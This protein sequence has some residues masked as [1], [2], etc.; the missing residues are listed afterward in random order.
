MHLA[1]AIG[2]FLC[3]WSV[4]YLIDIYFRARSFKRYIQFVESTGLVISPFQVRWYTSLFS[5]LLLSSSLLRRRWMR[6]FCGGWF[7]VGVAAA[8]AAS[9]FTTAFLTM[10]IW[11]QLGIGQLLFSRHRS[12]MT[13][14]Y[15]NDDDDLA[16]AAYSSSSRYND[17]GVVSTSTLTGHSIATN[18]DIGLIPIVP[19]VNVPWSQVPMFLAALAMAGIFHEM[20]RCLLSLSICHN[21]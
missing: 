6:V 17:G 14:N 3:F 12:Q 11:R 19:G 5:P 7:S 20:G 16:A 21:I 15:S 1:T 4:L 10:I 2:L 18:D 13:T 8:M 9:L